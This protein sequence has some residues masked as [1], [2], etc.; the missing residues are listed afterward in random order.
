MKI[1]NIGGTKA[2]SVRFEVSLI[3]EVKKIAEAY[4]TNTADFIRKAVEKE[5]ENVKN[6]FFYKLSQVEFCSDEES[7]EIAKELEKMESRD[8]EIVNR[9]IIE[10]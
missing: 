2:I 7:T 5:V 8:L 3:E 10:I 4:S 9:E 1:E 6:D